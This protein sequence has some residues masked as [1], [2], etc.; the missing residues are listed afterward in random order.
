MKMRQVQ[1]DHDPTDGKWYD[2]AATHHVIRSVNSLKKANEK[3]RNDT[4]LHETVKLRH[5]R[6]RVKKVIGSMKKM[7]RSSLI[8][9]HLMFNDT[10]YK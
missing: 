6:Y 2:R 4:D 10:D 3:N 5:I 7:D 9:H 8:W 1:R